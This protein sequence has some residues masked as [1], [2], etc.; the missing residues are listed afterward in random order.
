[1]NKAEIT[2]AQLAAW[3]E[4]YRA[5]P[6]RK[7]A[8]LALGKTDLNE[9]AFVPEGAWKMRQKF[10]V[11]IETLEVTSQQASGRCWLFAATNV[12][13]EHIARELKLE[14][15]E[16]SQSFLAFWDKFERCEL[17][18][19]RAV[20]D[21]AGLPA[22]DRAVAHPARHRR[23]RRRPVGYVRQHRGEVRRGAQG[24]VRRDLSSPATPRSMNARA[25][26]QA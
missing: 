20:I 26:P 4:S 2:Q 6:Q 3:S 17:S 9:V 11:E 16:L 12:L 14:K 1:M 25:Q 24:R 22:D 15:F 10:S 7:L 5:C 21:T 13:R 19:C 23:A 8:A 18:A